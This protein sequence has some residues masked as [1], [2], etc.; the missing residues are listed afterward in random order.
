[1]N[2]LGDR[3]YKWFLLRFNNKVVSTWLSDVQLNIHGDNV[4]TRMDEQL[5]TQLK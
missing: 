5:D 2:K 1:M 3:D 4:V